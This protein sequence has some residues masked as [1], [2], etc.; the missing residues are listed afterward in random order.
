MS[1][2]GQVADPGPK[3]KQRFL[4]KRFVGFSWEKAMEKHGKTE[5][6]FLHATLPR[7]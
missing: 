3:P 5:S 7:L 2:W 4:L 6:L 1:S